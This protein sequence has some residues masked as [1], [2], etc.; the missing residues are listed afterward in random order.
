MRVRRD[1]TWQLQ[2]GRHLINTEISN[3]GFQWLAGSL[4]FKLLYSHHPPLPPKKIILRMNIKTQIY[5]TAVK[6][7]QVQKS[8][9]SNVPLSQTGRVPALNTV[10]SN[11]V[12]SGWSWESQVSSEQ[13][14]VCMHTKRKEILF[15]KKQRHTGILRKD[16]EHDWKRSEA[17]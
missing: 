9:K 7:P 12:Q 5:C 13:T 15:A 8:F 1:Q 17:S 3:A 16:S 10:S 4:I 6:C 11:C 14:R 2:W